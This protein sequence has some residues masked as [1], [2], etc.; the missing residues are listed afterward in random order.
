MD[1]QKR[2]ATMADVAK[3]AGTTAATVSYVLNGSKDRYISAEMRQRVEAAAKELNY[4]KSSV[5]SSLKGK[6]KKIIAVLV[7]QFENQFF[8][9]LVLSIELIAMKYGY[10]LSIC[11]TFDDPEQEAEIINRMQALRVDG[12]VITP[13]RA[14][15]QNTEQI[16]TIGVP[17]VIVDRTLDIEDD[18]ALV[19][20]QNYESVEQAAEYLVH[21]GHRRI[22]YIGWDMEFHG[23]ERRQK[24]FRE[25][26]Q[27]HQI[28]SDEYV[29][30]NG[31]FNAASGYAMTEKV[32]TENPEVT[33]ILY[34]YNI[35]AKGGVD[36]LKQFRKKPGRDISVIIV[37]APDWAQTGNNDFTCI[38][39]NGA[40]MGT[41]A[42]EL[43]FET[44]TKDRVPAEHRIV[45]P[46]SLV[47]GSSVTTVTE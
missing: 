28:S 46:C 20:S 38:E 25:V 35:Q 7:P 47:E 1:Y 32:L 2:Y 17:M 34:A 29:R 40:A 37:G 45:Q 36:C 12:Y 27:K 5:A 4:V 13:S 44:L 30:L 8:T 31:P 24:A 15:G 10:I 19:S 41:K 16:R 21:H 14:G 33:A 22:A 18:Y 42:A 39:L 26:M 11:N 23:L 3:R 6:R 9:Q 43:L